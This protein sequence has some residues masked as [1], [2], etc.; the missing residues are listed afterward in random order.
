MIPDTQDSPRTGSQ[1]STRE[2]AFEALRSGNL[3][4]ALPLLSQLVEEHPSD[5]E[6]QAYLG[7]AYGHL[8][9]HEQATGCLAEATRLAPA[10]PALHY[11]HGRALEQQGRLVD[12]LAAYRTAVGLDA[13]HALAAA[14]VRRLHPEHAPEAP[15]DRTI[16]MPAR[17]GPV[18]A[19]PPVEENFDPV[20]LEAFVAA[21]QSRPGQAG[22]PRRTRQL[23]AVA[24]LVGLFFILGILIYLVALIAGRQ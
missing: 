24:E 5:A 19:A 16:S 7:V 3:E 9:M 12:A 21:M 14:A 15:D 1:P 11:N 23:R 2:A 8:G 18:T 13:T 20:A 6:A 17:P 10:V 22:A 4:Q